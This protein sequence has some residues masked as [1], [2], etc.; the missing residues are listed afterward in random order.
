MKYNPKVNEVVAS[1]PGFAFLHPL[2]P[3]SQVQGALGILHQLE[4]ALCEIG[5]MDRATLQPAAGAQGELTAVL[6]V[7]AFLDSRG[8]QKRR[9][10][11]VPDSS[12][13]TNPATAAR[14]GMEVVH[15]HSGK[16]GLVD[17]RALEVALD[18]QVAVVMLTNPNTLGLFEA[19]VQEVCDLVH[20]RGALA[21]CDG[22]NLNAILG[23]CRPGDLGFDAMH[24]NLHKTF[25]TPHGGGGP[26]AGPVGVK[27]FL[28]PFLPVPIV[29]ES[30]EGRFFLDFDRPDSIGSVHSFYGNF[31]VCVRAL[32]YI[33]S[34]GP[35]GLRLVAEDAVLNA[36]YLRQLIESVYEVPYPV[37]NLHEFVV[38][39]S[40]FVGKGVKTL[41][42]AKRLMDFG[43]HPPTMYFPLIVP[44]ALMIEPTDSET[45]ETLE[46]FA[47][48]LLRIADEA[49]NSPELILSSPHL[50]PVRRVNEVEAA[51]ILNVCF[52]QQGQK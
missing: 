4:R 43:F 14:A 45:K 12:H 41:D 40:R 51:R 23:V 39:T 5:G 10:V 25:S 13:G 32:A 27:E 33:L 44:D 11:L 3:E 30:A 50:T 35:P 28:A 29:E 48:A 8:E 47:E 36:R 22:A 31:A 1:Y 49:E 52:P 7:K 6:M 19:D 26:G 9:K 15:I 42:I 46:S 20:R 21:Y 18:D 34:L 17:L 38:S 24:F 2:Q 37:E 16:N